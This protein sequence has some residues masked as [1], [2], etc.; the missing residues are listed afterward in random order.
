MS[1]VKIAGHC[2]LCDGPCFEVMQVFDAHELYPGEPKR[3]GPPVEGAVRV[4]FLLFDG[5]K[6]HLTFCG[7]CAKSLSPEQYTEIWR[8][9]LRSWLRELKVE[10]PPWFLQQFSNGLLH[11]LGR[12]PWTDIANG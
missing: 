1:S 11:E 6:T 5:T 2:T 7:D 8:K 12:Q 10:T 3:L 9:N 4:T